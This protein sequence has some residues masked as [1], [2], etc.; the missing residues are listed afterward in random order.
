MNPLLR[1]LLS[2]YMAPA[3]DDGT[4]TGGTDTVGTD[5]A[6]VDDDDAYMALS[7]DERSRLRGD[8]ATESPSAD[9]LAALVA[10][11]ERQHSQGEAAAAGG[12]SD[13]A[14]GDKG[15]SGIPRARFNE[16]NEQRKAAEAKAAELEAEL[17]RVRG[18]Q[19]E[20]P[21]SAAGPQ[22]AASDL[23]IQEAEEQY[24]QLML[25]GDTKAAAALRLKINT[26]IEV[27]VL[28]RFQQTSASER[29]RGQ[30][31]EA[32]DQ[33]MQQFPWLESPEGSQ[34]LEL[35]E[36]SMVMKVQRGI[37]HA[38]AIRESVQAIAPRFAPN[39]TPAPYGVRQAGAA[40]G[41][42]RT[43]RANERGA[44]HSMQQPPLP[45]AG[46]GNRTTPATVDTSRLS[47]EEYMALPEAERKKA[48][49]D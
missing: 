36:A 16:V 21:V 3:G 1:K 46:M 20:G 4:D 6:T 45:Q 15:G 31:N 48:R 44:A 42:M 41:D 5:V 10:E 47:D 27:A 13:D 8:H 11:G 34:A 49:G 37:P 22:A 39:P 9:T 43:Q 33:M 24:A 7:A 32:V 14:G 12:E 28:E 17:A 19:K 2:R 38:Q 29:E 30:A 25:D 18:G 26:A 23:S 40:S 35:I